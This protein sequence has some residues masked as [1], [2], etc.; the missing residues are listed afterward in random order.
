[1]QIC[2]VHHYF[3]GQF[4]RLA[5]HFVKEGHDVVAFHRGIVDGRSSTP[6]EGVR[7]IEYGQELPQPSPDEGVLAGTTRFIREAASL[8][9]RAGEL[10]SEGW[11]P[12]VIYS[13][14]GWGSAAY[15]HDVFPRAKYVKFCEWYYNNK[16][17]STEYLTPGGR[18]LPQRMATTTLNLPILADLAHGDA[19]ISP[20]E[21]QKSQ[22]PPAVRDKIEVVPDGVD[23][24]FFAPDAAATFTLPDG[25]TIGRGNRIVTYA[26]RGADPFR[27]FG[28][29]MEALADLQARDP[30]I[31]AI[32]LGDKTVYYGSGSGTEDHFNAVISKTSIDASRTHFLG[33]VSYE[34]YRRV[35]QISSAHIYLTV[36]FVLS[37]SFLEAMASGC[38]VVGSDTAPVREFITN[39]ENGRLA[40][41]FDPKDVADRIADLLD[42]DS[43]TDALRARARDTIRKRW[44]AEIAIERHMA[45]VDRLL[46]ERKKGS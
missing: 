4:A 27:G 28:P 12:D 37:W 33:R 44:S 9:T 5:R 7:L 25:R 10:R 21:W 6:I 30:L 8:A 38:A 18:A 26:A 15:L 39:G 20:T 19:L 45:V 35:L 16:T 34:D 17:S 11:R 43:E 40:N 46:S 41:F 14:T 29:F 2:F 3:P 31:E 1:M 22:F 42:C 32:V 13:H 36:P 23:L 24:D